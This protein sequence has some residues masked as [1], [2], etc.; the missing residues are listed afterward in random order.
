LQKVR[1]GDHQVEVSLPDIDKL[2][3]KTPV[4]VDDIISTARTMIAATKHV[5]SA[6]LSRPLCVGVHAVFASSAYED[7]L[8]SGAE[9]VITCN[10]IPHPTNSIDVYQ[11]LAD[12]IRALF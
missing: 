8:G 6:G 4:L 7:L 1:R 9:R 3:G 11:D 2:R 10:T 12:G 5:V